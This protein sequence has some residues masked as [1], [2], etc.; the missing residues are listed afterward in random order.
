MPTV[1]ITAPMVDDHQPFLEAV[2]H[3]KTLHAHW[4]SP[5]ATEAAFD[6]YLS[7]VSRAD[8]AGLFI[9]LDEAGAIAGVVNVSNIVRGPM[10]CGFL[11]FYALEPY[12]NQGTMNAGL[13]LVLERALGPLAFH[14]LEANI[15]PTNHASLALVLTCGFR[16]EGFSSKYLRIAGEWRDHECWALLA[17][18]F[19]SRP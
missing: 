14:R 5:P 15:Q 18:E 17:E 9:R 6:E 4:V 1:S 19:Q 11:G 3:S 16:Q 8:H 12:A 7:R 10:C 13:R 2:A